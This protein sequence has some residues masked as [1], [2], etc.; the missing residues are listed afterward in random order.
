MRI[1]V[2]NGAHDN[3]G[4]VLTREGDA[5][6]YSAGDSRPRVSGKGTA[7]FG[8][9]PESELGPVCCCLSMW[10]EPGGP[11]T[12]S[13]ALFPQIRPPGQTTGDGRLLTPSSGVSCPPVQDGS[14]R[15]IAASGSQAPAP[16][17]PDPQ[18]LQ[19]HSP[20]PS[21]RGPHAPGAPRPS[22]EYPRPWSPHSV[23]CRVFSQP[24]VSGC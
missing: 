12:S 6:A 24:C 13:P 2:Q 15:R 11:R 7:R 16:P 20:L 5:A 8:G 3:W 21:P 23:S 9:R 19:V 1:G 18:P 14:S 10:G 17:N 4:S 22:R